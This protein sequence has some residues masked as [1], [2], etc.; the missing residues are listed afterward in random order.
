M[1]NQKFNPTRTIRN[2][3]GVC[4]IVLLAG[5]AHAQTLVSNQSE[6]FKATE[7]LKPGDTIVLANGTWRDFEIVF[8]GN[9][10]A[11]N[12]ITLTAETKGK[13]V[14]SGE[15][16]LR[17]AGKHLIVSG[18]VFK[19]GYTPTNTVISFR[20]TKG[21]LAYHSRITEI[22]IDQFNNPE[23][24]ETDFWVMM[25]GQY[26]R[27]DHNYLVGKSNKGVT[28]AV[29][30]D[31]PE[32]QEN[33]HL[34]DHNYFGHRPLLGSNGGETLRI[35]TSHYSLADSFTVVESNYF[36]E[37]SGEVEIVSSKSG[38]N[39]FSGNVFLRSQ[40]TLTLR[41]GNDNIIENNVFLG[42]SQ[43]H[44][45]G[46]R[47]INKR[48]TVR[49][50]YLHGLT[51][52]RF[53]GALVIMNG[54]PNSP[55][56]RYHQVEDSSI[57]GNSIIDSSHIELAAGSDAER[58][59]P[60]ITSS[61]R[62][63]LIY[64]E[65]GEDTIAI[66]DDISGIEFSSNVANFS[67]RE[68][69]RHGIRKVE[70]NL[71][72]ESNG[73]FY[74]T[75]ERLSDVGASRSLQVLK[76]DETGP[77]WYPKRPPRVPFGSGDEILVQPKEH[78]LDEA[79]SMAQAGDVLVLEGGEYIATKTLP[80]HTTI[81]IR[82]RSESKPN[83]SFERNALFEIQDGGSLSLEGLSISGHSSPDMAGNSLIRTKRHSMLG[84]YDLIIKNTTIQNLDTNHSF[85]VLSLAKHTFARR[86]AIVNS[87]F[88][89][90]TGHVL[91]MNQEIDDL[92][93]Y[94]V[95]YVHIENSVF[96]NVG[97]AVANIYR[98]GTDESTF[99][100][101]FSLTDSTI[102]STGLNSRNKTRASVRLFGVQDTLISNNR[103]NSSR[104][105]HVIHT[106]GDP[107]T[108][109]DSNKFVD[110]PDAVVETW[111]RE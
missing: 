50:N 71:K 73:L 60:P 22:V 56:N 36:E 84:N 103:F 72:R 85:N 3:C 37:C 45:G 80:I 63:N 91:Q 64:N 15:S 28:M 59:A 82:A 39:R 74:P 44:T 14:I 29:R 62:R 69:L 94:N 23:R 25:Y 99:G 53:G 19:D 30:L 34:I 2:L 109:I 107:I 70:L 79:L 105:I 51:G 92:G 40:G 47:V 48:Q 66:H 61:F 26:N 76:R 111:K 16:N 95:E 93:I 7:N 11:Q 83:I 12:P 1:T 90:I 21:E 46:I 101:H 98:G 78:A 41:H 58:S 57:E 18:L 9:G 68:E 104:P 106:V 33:H 31:S 96:S 52:H 20:R 42:E 24:H 108:R 6:F 38:G 49:N 86:V 27:F 5:V 88:E 17:I 54:V 32:S 75:A 87:R 97:G 81:T 35:G 43:P 65:L 100:P 102:E 4:S 55:I 10:T 13:V 89:N 8:E 110:T 77:D 67:P